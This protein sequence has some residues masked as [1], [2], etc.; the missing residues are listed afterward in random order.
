MPT[1]PFKVCKVP[2]VFVVGSEGSLSSVQYVEVSSLHAHVPQIPVA[3][4][5]LLF[6]A[7]WA[8]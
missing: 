3:L 5:C 2:T 7:K 6:P 1:D 4:F 8:N